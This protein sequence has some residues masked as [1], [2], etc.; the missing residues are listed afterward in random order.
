MVSRYK[1]SYFVKQTLI[2]KLRNI[3]LRNRYAELAWVNNKV[4]HTVI[5]VCL[6]IATPVFSM[7]IKFSKKLIMH[8]PSN[9]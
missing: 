1:Y 5:I 9:K 8:K 2:T 4:F 3:G 6:V 7:R